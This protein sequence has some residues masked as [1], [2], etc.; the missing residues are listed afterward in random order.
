MA[1]ASVATIAAFAS[2]AISSSNRSKSELEIDFVRANLSLQSSLDVALEA[3][4]SDVNWRATYS[5]HQSSDTA[6]EV[7][8]GH[9][10]LKWY[11]S[12]PVDANLVNQS[13]DPLRIHAVGQHEDSQR[14]ISILGFPGGRALEVLRS[15]LHATGSITLQGTLVSAQGPVSTDS[16][17]IGNSQS[18]FGDVEAAS[19]TGLSRAYHATFALTDAKAMP[20]E[21]VFDAYRSLASEIDIDTLDDAYTIENAVVSNQSAPS[22][23]TIVNA[24]AIY[25]LDVPS[26]T[27]LEIKNSKIT[28]TLLIRLQGSHAKL[29][30]GQGVYWNPLRKDF[31]SLIVM[32]ETDSENDVEIACQGTFT[33][34][35]TSES[36]NASLNGIFH[37]LRPASATSETTIAASEPIRGSILVEGDVT[38]TENSFLMA[39]TELLDQQI[40]GYQTASDPTQM[41]ENGD[42]D[43]GISPWHPS[44][45]NYR[46][47]G[48]QIRRSNASGN[49]TNCVQVSRRISSRSGI[50]CDVT[51]KLEA[52]VTVS[53]S[54]SAK[55]ND[56]DE[57]LVIALIIEDDNGTS[58]SILATRDATTNWTTFN[59]SLSPSWTGSLDSA[60]LLICTESTAQD[61]FLD[62]AS[63]TLSPSNPRV[64]IDIFPATA[65]LE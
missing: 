32:S 64:K 17:L 15:P 53:G 31:P 63:V 57:T 49:G 34:P 35:F 20:S 33:D 18:V 61:F 48:T 29:K 13:W 59:F 58:S 26:N 14:E 8:L 5:A 40:R 51:S 56:Q 60:T 55:M 16:Q 21:L 6:V 23:G 25:S 45:G 4:Q 27:T 19:T 1:V 41:L 39:D 12:D 42:F 62:E 65:S 2:L 24:N 50:A 44:D 28:G 30:L 36:V 7:S 47:G 3:I 54:V 38:I 22:S 10:T 46:A 37:I 11:L 52:G 43:T 9:S